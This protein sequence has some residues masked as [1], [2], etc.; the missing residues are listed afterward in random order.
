MN[1][2]ASHPRRAAGVPLL[3]RSAPRWSRRAVLR[4]MAGGAAV[5]VGLPLLDLFLNDSGTALA[6]GGPLP[7]RDLWQLKDLPAATDNISA[8]VPRHGMVFL[9]VGKGR[10]EGEC[11]KELV[12]ANTSAK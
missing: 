7:V 4:G 9:K 1:R 11:V 6:Q 8:M 5:T 10:S 12:K 3:R 2:E